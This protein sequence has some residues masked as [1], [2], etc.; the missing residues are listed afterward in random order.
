MLE[1]EAIL[2][3]L[4]ASVQPKLLAGKREMLTAGQTFEAIDPMTFDRNTL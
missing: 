2:A 1:P 4:L 3:A